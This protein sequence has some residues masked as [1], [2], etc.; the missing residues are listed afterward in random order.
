MNNISEYIIEKLKL[1]KDS[2]LEKEKAPRKP[3]EAD[4]YV[5]YLDK[6]PKT[7]LHCK[8]L[9]VYPKNDDGR[10]Q[11][12]AD[13]D[14]SNFGKNNPGWKRIPGVKTRSQ[15]GTVAS[16]KKVDEYQWY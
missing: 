9:G 5:C 6:G 13:A 11:A 2:K 15:V 8:W 12:E 16:N 7:Y 3:S 1:D 14:K 10:K 4:Y